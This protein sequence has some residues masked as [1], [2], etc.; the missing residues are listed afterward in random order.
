[1]RVARG[2]T[3][4]DPNACVLLCAV[5]LCTVHQQYGW[6]PAQTTANALFADGAAAIVGM[7]TSAVPT[8]EIVDV[9]GPV[10]RPWRVVGGGSAIIPDTVDHMSWRIGDHGFRMTLSRE[11][12]AI[13]ESQLGDWLHPWLASFGLT[14]ADVG[15]WAAHP[16]GPKILAG[17]AAGAGVSMDEMQ[18]SLDIL[19]NYGNMSSPTVLFVLEQLRKQNAALPCVVLGFGPG[20]AIEAALIA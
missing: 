13:I 20:L 18:V 16:G 12:P 17:T 5:E 2:L 8:A 9:K 7:Q 4:A 3:A 15:C 1:M 11:V 19:A 14:V 10:D 6:D